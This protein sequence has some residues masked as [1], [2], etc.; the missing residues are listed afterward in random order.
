M[1]ETPE[2]RRR[3]LA[4]TRRRRKRRLAWTAAALVALAAAGGV[5]AT[6][7]DGS[8]HDVDAKATGAGRKSAPLPVPPG[9]IPGYLL[10]ADRG[11]N[12]IL[13]VDGKKRILWRYPR[14]FHRP[15]FPFR[16]GDDA[17]FG[18]GLH[19]IV[20]NQ[21]DQDTLQ[22]IS[23]PRGRLLWSYGHINVRGSSPGYLNTPD[24]AYLLPNGLRSVAD[25][26]N[27]RVLL[28][29]ATHRI[30]RQLGRTRACVHNPPWSLGSVNGATPL[31]DG[32][33]LVSEIQGSWIDR[34]S[35]AG[36]LLWSFRAP[37]SYPS[38]PQW[39]GGGKI[40]LADYA[41]PGHAL[42]LNTRGRVLW[43]YGPSSGWGMLDHPS[44]ALQLRPGLIAVNDDYR[45]RVVL[46][47]VATKRI[48]WLYGHTGVKGARAGY[49]NTPDGMD[50]LP[51]ARLREVPAIRALAAVARRRGRPVRAKASS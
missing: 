32:G 43:R 44:L 50:L 11:N 51:A 35:R 23:F 40:L 42:I 20:T 3:R 39:L 24:D 27:C 22:V 47:D 16:Y 41:R 1:P 13:L 30:A 15:G 38:D 19:S 21:E 34:F 45:N 7:L 6:I 49:L 25:A 5:S 31:P 48:V 36:R 4:V 14:P 8:D 9:P 17:F 28:I 46:I 2:Q 29:S 10:I 33:F 12:R 26:Y 37:V 18:P